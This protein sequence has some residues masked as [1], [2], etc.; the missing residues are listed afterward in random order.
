MTLSDSARVFAGLEDTRCTG[1][2]DLIDGVVAAHE[3]GW[4]I[5]LYLQAREL[6]IDIDELSWATDDL[7][8][9]PEWFIAARRCGC[10]N[11]EI[12]VC[13]TMQLGIHSYLQARQYGAS[14]EQYCE[15][16]RVLVRV[17][18]KSGSRIAGRDFQPYIRCLAGGASHREILE[19]HGRGLD[20]NSYADFRSEGVEHETALNVAFSALYPNSRSFG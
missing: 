6:G 13:V 2:T 12:T 19:A 9:S 18:R 11:A 5:E 20:L 15:A 16:H 14:H 10:T 7:G 1:D 8:Q 3:A 17:D 4:D